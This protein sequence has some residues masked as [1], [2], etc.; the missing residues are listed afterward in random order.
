[1]AWSLWVEEGTAGQAA[2]LAARLDGA[3]QARLARIGIR[4]LRPSQG[5]AL[6]EAALHRREANLVV[7]PFDL[8][9]ASREVGGGVPPRWRALV[10]RAAK[11]AVYTRES[12]A[13]EIRV[14]SP[15]KRLQTVLDAVRTEVARALSLRGADAVPV[16]HP[17]KELGLDSLMAVELRN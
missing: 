9:A 5:I 7:V 17:L 3:Q 2:G 4:P 13:E 15:E 8:R 16:D 14:L 6:L 12:W 11:Q 10:R 1:L